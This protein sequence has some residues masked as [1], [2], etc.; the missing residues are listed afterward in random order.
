MDGIRADDVR[1]K[2]WGGEWIR[3][4]SGNTQQCVR[5]ESECN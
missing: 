5:S 4:W 2:I 3:V 1:I